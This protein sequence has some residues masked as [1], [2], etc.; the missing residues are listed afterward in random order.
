MCPCMWVAAAQGVLDPARPLYGVGATAPAPPLPSL[1][2][3][4]VRAQGESQGIC[5]TL[6]DP[7]R[8][9]LSLQPEGKVGWQVP[10]WLLGQKPGLQE[11]GG[12]ELKAERGRHWGLTWAAAAIASSVESK[13][14]S[15][16]FASSTWD[17]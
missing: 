4:P 14:P 5:P 1:T 15:L 13:F 7:M 10:M 17:G 16:S 3:G 6:R 11:T 2:Q 8:K 9:V 12:R